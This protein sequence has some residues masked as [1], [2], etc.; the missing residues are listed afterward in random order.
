MPED[1]H[2]LPFDQQRRL[3]FLKMIL[4]HQR[5]RQH[6]ARHRLAGSSVQLELI[7]T[8]ENMRTAQTARG[9]DNLR[10]REQQSTTRFFQLC[11]TDGSRGNVY[12]KLPIVCACLW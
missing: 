6:H 9:G 3:L 8:K 1:I 12:L 2:L 10:D 11:G 4:D 5:M 7:G